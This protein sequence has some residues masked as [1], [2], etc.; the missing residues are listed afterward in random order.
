MGAVLGRFWG[1]IEG[2]GGCGAALAPSGVPG[3]A[4]WVRSRAAN[5]RR[6]AIEAAPEGGGPAPAPG[7][8]ERGPGPG[9]PGGLSAPRSR[10]CA[11][12]AGRRGRRGGT[13][14]FGWWAA[15]ARC[16]RVRP[17]IKPLAGP[18][19]VRREGLGFPGLSMQG[20]PSA[21]GSG[22]APPQTIS[23][24][25]LSADPPTPSVWTLSMCFASPKS[26]SWGGAG[27]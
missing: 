1:E 23:A 26:I 20:S 8:W 25:P 13:R 15:G 7:P 27:I 6:P 17:Q 5:G 12:G 22:P 19:G 2:G 16:T 18:Q 21:Q 14:E 24:P 10:A 4:E 9:P 3:P 11:R